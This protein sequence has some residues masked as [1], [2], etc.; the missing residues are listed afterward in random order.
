MEY[1]PLKDQKILKTTETEASQKIFHRILILH[2]E[3]ME[4]P[5]NP[6]QAN[7]GEL[8]TKST[9]SKDIQTLDMQS[10]I[11]RQNGVF[12]SD[13]FVDDA[14]ETKTRQVSINDLPHDILMNIFDELTPCMVVCLGLT[15]RR[16]YASCK[17]YHP[18]PFNLASYVD[19]NNNQDQTVAFCNSLACC[20]L[21]DKIP[22]TPMYS[23][24]RYRSRK[25][26]IQTILR[27]WYPGHGKHLVDLI[28]NW[29]GLRHYRKT[30]L[31]VGGYPGLYFFPRYLL[32]STYNPSNENCKAKLALQ[33]R[34]KDYFHHVLLHGDSYPIP[35]R[36]SN[37]QLRGPSWLAIPNP[38]QME[39]RA[40]FLESKEIILRDRYVHARKGI[41]LFHWRNLTVG[42]GCEDWLEEEL[43]NFFSEWREMM[44]L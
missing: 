2:S 30:W 39:P 27:E 7:C 23:T 31:D 22:F 11:K 44:G 21:S 38:L 37:P 43:L 34:Y 26:R 6:E 42:Q 19:P 8:I 18:K 4:S 16:F 5:G 24:V 15:C 41:W 1:P 14:I 28:E 20:Q 13:Y 29:Q 25:S 17:I 35:H 10:I 32:I 40:W 12:N 3:I 36:N 9:R 33:Q